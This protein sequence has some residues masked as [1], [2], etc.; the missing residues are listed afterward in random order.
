MS[1]N[2]NYKPCLLFTTTCSFATN[3]LLYQICTNFNWIRVYGFDF[4]TILI[5]ILVFKFCM[6]V[7]SSNSFLYTINYLIIF[8]SHCVNETRYA[9]GICDRT[10]RERICCVRAAYKY[11]EIS[12]LTVKQ[13]VIKIKK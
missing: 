12:T 6:S 8:L 10:I 4:S 5:S 3:L 11:G 7:P 9:I 2:R 13:C 1:T